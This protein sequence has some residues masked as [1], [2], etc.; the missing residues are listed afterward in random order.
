MEDMIIWSFNG[1]QDSYEAPHPKIPW[2][3]ASLVVYVEP[4]LKSL[5]STIAPLDLPEEIEYCRNHP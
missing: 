5:I 1:R 4:S 3:Q 2:M